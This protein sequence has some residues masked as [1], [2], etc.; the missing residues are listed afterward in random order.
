MA[1]LKIYIYIYN[2]MLELNISF[3]VYWNVSQISLQMSMTAVSLLG[4]IG[5]SVQGGI[6][7]QN[8]LRTTA[9]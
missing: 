9:L 6:P 1:V 8:E 2:N 4:S 5:K 3:D 7:V